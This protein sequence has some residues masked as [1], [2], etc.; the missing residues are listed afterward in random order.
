M[1]YTEVQLAFHGGTTSME[2]VTY[3]NVKIREI[4]EYLPTAGHIKQ[5]IEIVEA[6]L[7]MIRGEESK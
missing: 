3:D 1:G 4:Q 7:K 5:Q 2:M 6:E